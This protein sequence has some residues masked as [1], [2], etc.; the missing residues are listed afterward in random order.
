MSPPSFSLAPAADIILTGSI[1]LSIASIVV[2]AGTVLPS[3]SI[4]GFT[5]SRVT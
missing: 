4:A 2:V 1:D 3:W 5:Q